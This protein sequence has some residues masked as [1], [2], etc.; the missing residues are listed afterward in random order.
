MWS[1]IMRKRRNNFIYIVMIILCILTILFTSIVLLRKQ[2]LN[3]QQED[4]SE[5]EILNTATI[6][7]ITIDTKPFG[8]NEII[9]PTLYETLSDEEIYLLEVTIQHEVGNFS[10]EYKRL[11]AELIYNRYL[12]EDF[13]NTITGV[14]FQKGQFQGI[15][16]WAYSG[17]IIDDETKEV[18][19]DV[20][21]EETTS[22]PATFY[23]NPELS[24]YNSI[25]WFEYSGD[26]DFVFEHTEIDWGISYNTRFFV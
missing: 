22:H 13:P 2:T 3:K 18:I 24:E 1:N 12:S 14:L 6:I 7:H 19:K 8:K 20:F 5:T 17:I 23:Y 4:V 9:E 21:S 16:Q 26:V 11:V 10:K 15:Q 25:V